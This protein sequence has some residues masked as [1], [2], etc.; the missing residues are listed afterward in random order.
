MPAI[1]SRLILSQSGAKFIKFCVGLVAFDILYFALFKKLI[2]ANRLYICVFAFLK[3]HHLKLSFKIYNSRFCRTRFVC[4]RLFNVLFGCGML[5]SDFEALCGSATMMVLLAYKNLKLGK[6]TASKKGSLLVCVLAASCAFCGGL[7]DA[8][9]A[10]FALAA[11]FY[12]CLDRVNSPP[13]S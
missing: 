3:A 6:I 8:T 11:C 2:I 10:G 9:V 12:G 13:S 1:A 7:L 4:L 5:P